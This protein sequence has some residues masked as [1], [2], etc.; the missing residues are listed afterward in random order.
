VDHYLLH[1][2]QNLTNPVNGMNLPNGLT[3]SLD[4]KTSSGTQLSK[5]GLQL[6]CHLSTFINKVDIRNGSKVTSE[7]ALQLGQLCMS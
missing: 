2:F 1:A 6:K 7:E 3:Q 4:A 5:F